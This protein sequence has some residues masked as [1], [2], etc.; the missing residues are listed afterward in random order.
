MFV[1]DMNT[2]S[3]MW[4]LKVDVN[5]SKCLSNQRIDTYCLFIVV[6]VFCGTILHQLCL[7]QSSF[8]Q[9]EVGK[10]FL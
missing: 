3:K 7:R 9:S 10:F 6:V 5:K 8:L 2:S 1:I 4:L